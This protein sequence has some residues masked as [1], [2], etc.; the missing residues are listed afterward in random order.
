MAEVTENS[1]KKWERPPRYMGV[2]RSFNHDRGFGFVQSY[3]DGQSYFCHISQFKDDVPKRG[4]VVE[5]AIHT[6]KEGKQCCSN[7]LVVEVP[8]RH[9]RR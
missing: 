5:F 3:E 6:N 4:M 9:R 8:E 1:K 7:C 2:I